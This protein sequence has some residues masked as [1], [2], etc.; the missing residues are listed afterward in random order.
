[1][2]GRAIAAGLL[3][4]L[5]MLFVAFDLVL[6]G[7]VPLNSVLVTILPAVGLV[8]GVIFGIL[9]GKRQ[10]ELVAVAVTPA[11]PAP[12]PPPDVYQNGNPV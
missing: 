5:F 1:M 8:L 2:V 12:L 11:A 9:A 7:V 10:R 3:G 4:L 6:F